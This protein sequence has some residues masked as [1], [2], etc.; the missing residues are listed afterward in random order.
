MDS[1][2]D[3]YQTILR[4]LSGMNDFTSQH[5]MG[6]EKMDTLLAGLGENADESQQLT[7]LTELCNFLSIGTEDTVSGFRSDA[8]APLLVQCMR[9]EHNIDIMLLAARALTH[10]MEALPSSCATVVAAGAVPVFCEKLLAIE[11]IDLAEQ[12]L[13]ALEKLS[14]E[15][16][17]I[18]IKEGALAAMLSFIDFFGISIQRKVVHTAANLCKRV[19]KACFPM[20]A[21]TI[22]TLTNFLTYDDS[23]LVEN[24]VLCFSRLV[25]SFADEEEKLQIILSDRLVSSL[26]DLIGPKRTDRASGAGNDA[27][28]DIGPNTATMIL[29]TLGVAAR[30]SLSLTKVMLNNGLVALMAELLVA[31]TAQ[32]VGALD[33]ISTPSGQTPSSPPLRGMSPNAATSSATTP[34]GISFLSPVQPGSPSQQHTP[35]SASSLGNASPLTQKMSKASSASSEIIHETV[36]LFNDLLPTIQDGILSELEFSKRFAGRALVGGGWESA[37]ELADALGDSPGG[38]RLTALHVHPVVPSKLES[39]W[40]CDSPVECLRGL[41]RVSPAAHHGVPRWRCVAGCDW[42]ICDRCLALHGGRPTDEEEDDDEEEEME[43]ESKRKR[44][45]KGD[46]DKREKDKK[47]KELKDKAKQK[48]KEARREK[49]E[50]D[51]ETEKK[52]EPNKPTAREQMYQEHPELLQRIG[53]NVQYLIKVYSSTMHSSIQTKCLAILAKVVHFFPKDPL[54]DLFRTIP[55][56]GFLASLLH[57]GEPQALASSLH[58]AQCLMEKLPDV[59]KVHFIREG[60]LNE[61]SNLATK[62]ET[63]RGTSTSKTGSGSAVMGKLVAHAKT[64]ASRYY[65]TGTTGE[66]DEELPD[67]LCSEVARRLN[68]IAEGLEA[69]TRK[70]GDQQQADL[71]ELCSV[72]ASEDSV[73]TYEVITSGIINALLFYLTVP[74]SGADGLDRRERAGRFL[75][76]L[77]RNCLIVPNDGGLGAALQQAQQGASQNNYLQLLVQKLQAALA[78][79]ENFPIY[80]NDYAENNM[81]SST[82]NCLKMLMQ[83][84]KLTLIHDKGQGVDRDRDDI[85]GTTVMVEPL[86]TVGAVEDFIQSKL[87]AS[88]SPG[89]T[90]IKPPVD[91]DMDDEEE[92]E[93]DFHEEAETKEIPPPRRVTRSQTRE[94]REESTSK[95]GATPKKPGTS[96][97]EEKKE[98][99][100]EPVGSGSGRRRSTSANKEPKEKEKGKGDAEG[101][102]PNAEKEKGKDADNRKAEK[103]KEK[104]TDSP[105][106]N[107]S[108]QGSSA[109]PGPKA[110]LKLGG[111]SLSSGMTIFQCIHKHGNWRSP[112]ERQNTDSPAHLT[113][114]RMWDVCHTLYYSTVEEAAA[115][116]AEVGGSNPKKEET[117]DEAEKDDGLFVGLITEGVVNIEQAMND[118]L[119]NLVTDLGKQ[120]SSSTHSLLLLLRTLHALNSNHVA[121]IEFLSAVDEEPNDG[122]K[123]TQSRTPITFYPLHESEFFSPKLTNKL[124]CQ[125]HDPLLLCSGY[126]SSSWCQALA[127]ECPFLF[128]FATRRIFFE[129]SSFGATRAMLMLQERFSEQ[130]E[131]AQFRFGRVQKQKVRLSRAH[132]LESA[133]KVMTLYGSQKAF[134]EFEFFGEVGTGLGPTLEFYTLVSKAL[135]V[136]KLEMWRNEAEVTKKEDPPVAPEAEGSDSKN[137]DEKILDEEEDYVFSPN[138]LFPAPLKP[139]KDANPDILRLFTFLGEFMGRAMVDKRIIDLPLSVPFLKMLRSQPLCIDDIKTIRPELHGFL[140]K[141][142]S[143]VRQR[144][145]LEAAS[146][147]APPSAL[148][149]Q[150]E[151]LMID[152]VSIEDLCLDFTLP[153]YDDIPLRPGGKDIAVTLYNLEDYVDLVVKVMLNTS[154]AP[155]M[156]AFREGFNS[157]FPIRQMQLFSV[158]ELDEMFC[159]STQPI[160]M[161]QLEA[162]TVCDHGYTQNSRAVRF[163]YNIITNMT[164]SELRKFILFVT[165]AP[166]LPVGGLKNLKPPLT[167]VRKTPDPS[168]DVP[169]KVA[170]ALPSVMTCANYLKLPDYASEETMK[171]KLYLAMMEGQESFHLS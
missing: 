48:Q 114:R 127:I 40:V 132:I 160:N 130:G 57:S 45:K 61:I 95:K 139:E 49:K 148:K 119:R 47:E 152:D 87:L 1:Y 106:S 77:G 74:G 105:K 39:P 124:L 58:M 81:T 100:K 126:L 26:I 163:L 30:A 69:F 34:P 5:S 17:H 24:V 52:A 112:A 14:Q 56:A 104:E 101:K 157:I 117:M 11:F 135:Q 128:S 155:Q 67:V 142:L 72:M 71:H 169:W 23:K 109:D 38:T 118:T 12:C 50:K 167:V 4:R 121:L 19:P 129:L 136:A 89:Q 102:E 161:E 79:E 133:M 60:V 27:R 9:K 134:L 107:N 16:T 37:M 18:L 78:Q 59:Y 125:V 99:E 7:C 88:T 85:R 68:K 122:A 70:T 113:S 158:V 150:I 63:G 156:N 154:I 108:P 84:F 170:D 66:G 41:N 54:Q 143:L 111:Q 97:R 165:G 164:Q 144:Q 8:F 168:F 64:F 86:A 62:H 146:A 159:G 91:D 137:G 145:H 90:S 141:A 80:V 51:A 53:E 20:V 55:I 92:E 166:R 22:P 21:D 115:K 13:H 131:S 96:P 140:V 147:G 73:S 2:S 43:E 75:N 76:V 35:H 31:S 42:D 94:E 65:S 123:P 120:V 110:V 138:G 149:A 32:N 93:E 151:Q 6:R 44:G 83:P 116:K 15:H 46:K 29:R 28:Q 103:A 10:L 25:T 153:G 36:T 82:L 162:Y 33:S 171:E 98:K 3:P